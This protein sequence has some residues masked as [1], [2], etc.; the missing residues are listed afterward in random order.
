MPMIRLIPIIV[1][2][3]II[4]TSNA[5]A[6]SSASVEI[7]NNIYS[8]STSNSNIENKTNIRVETNGNVTEY[9]S[10][11]PNQK[12]E[13]KSVNG[14]SSIKVDGEE[15]TESEN[16]TKITATPTPT[17]TAPN[18]ETANEE[19][20]TENAIIKFI[21]K[22]LDFIKKFFSFLGNFGK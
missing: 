15:V 21:N 18:G 5:Y 11:E 7:N 4:I 1:L 6:E 8:T 13:V 12:I 14:E 3:F 10:D 22:P 20:N 16:E 2:F 19:L 9:S 17:R